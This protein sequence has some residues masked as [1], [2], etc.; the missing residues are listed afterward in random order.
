[1]DLSH[2]SCPYFLW[3]SKDPLKQAKPLPTTWL[4]VTV[5]LVWFILFYYEWSC[6]LICVIF[7]YC[8]VL[9]YTVLYCTVLYWHLSCNWNYTVQYCVLSCVFCDFIVLFC[10]ELYNMFSWLFFSRFYLWLSFGPYHNV[11]CFFV[12]LFL[13]VFSCSTCFY[14]GWTYYHILPV[15]TWKPTEP[16][17][18]ATKRVYTVIDANYENV[19]L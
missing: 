13:L 16:V 19:D 3:K 8:T 10:P 17:C 7:R 14:Y 1:M 6:I 4:T 15:K 2:L 12:N 9:Y 11:F 18:T 5:L